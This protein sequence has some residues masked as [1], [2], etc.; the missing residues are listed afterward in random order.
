[1]VGGTLKTAAGWRDGR[2]DNVGMGRVRK[3]N[4]SGGVSIRF[5]SRVRRMVR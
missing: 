4:D 2:V 1:M 3:Q 5:M